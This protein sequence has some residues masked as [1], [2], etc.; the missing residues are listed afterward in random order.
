MVKSWAGTKE[1]G[2]TLH[3]IIVGGQRCGTSS[4]VNHLSEHPEIDFLTE[5]HLHR[6]GEFIGWPFASPVISHF[7]KGYDPEVYRAFCRNLG[8]GKSV[9]GTRQ[10]YFMVFPHVP[11]GLKEHLPDVRLLFILR[12]QADA[13]YSTYRLARSNGKMA[14][15][16][17]F[18]DAI[19]YNPD[20][21][22]TPQTDNFG[23]PYS[24]SRWYREYWLKTI[25]EP[26]RTPFLLDRYFYYEQLVRY[27]RLFDEDQI[28]V[29]N[30]DDFTADVSGTLRRILAF[31]GLDPGFR[32]K[33]ATRVFGA[34][35]SGEE[36]T[37]ELRT[38]ID[39]LYRESNARLFR[40]LDW[41]AD[42]WQAGAAAA[43]YRAAVS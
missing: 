18:A 24:R 38:A 43:P 5:K 11:F 42:T 15:A 32:F 7:T 40:L 25:R 31:L 28:L 34:A 27:I 20:D 30:F 39:D 16:P 1:N 13:I 26:D 12:N 2:P 3:F 36:L 10:P 17:T 14:H 6:D 23:S 19:Q 37:P 8:N 4:L 41:P 22:S 9:I 21:G 35:P 33:T 29:L